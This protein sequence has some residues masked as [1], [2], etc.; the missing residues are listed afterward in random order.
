MP[1]YEA[2]CKATGFGGTPLIAQS[3]AS[4]SGHPVIARTV[5]V[6]FD[7]NVDVNMPWRFEPVQRSVDV[8]LGEEKATA[9]SSFTFKSAKPGMVDLILSPEGA[10]SITGMPGAIEVMFGDCTVSQRSGGR[11]TST[12]A[13]VAAHRA[14]YDYVLEATPMELVA[15]RVVS[16]AHSITPGPTP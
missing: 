9:S 4:G 11:F 16:V 3:D 1:L 7:S 2:F 10:A 12:A 15:V 6:R 14:A 5:A 8:H 13:L